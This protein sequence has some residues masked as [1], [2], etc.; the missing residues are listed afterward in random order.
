MSQLGIGIRLLETLTSALYEDP[1]VLF[2]EYVQ[3]SIDSFNRGK[4]ADEFKIDI[5]INEN[6]RVITI[7]D[8]GN[9]IAKSNFYKQ[10]SMIAGSDKFGEIDQIGFRGIGRLSAMPFCDELIFIN[11]ASGENTLQK[12]T[13]NGKKYKNL[14]KVDKEE[15][16]ESIVDEISNHEL[17]IPYDGDESD[18]FFKVEIK[19]YN[20]EINLL[21]NNED[22][23]ARLCLLLPL[24][25]DPEFKYK[26]EIHDHYKKFMNSDLKIFE[27]N[28]FLNGKPLYKL[29]K[30]NNILESEIIFWDLYFSK[31]DKSLPSEKI[32][33]IWF[34]FSRKLVI[35]G[36]STLRGI[37][38]RSKNMLLGDETSIVSAVMK[39]N[40]EYIT[41]RRELEQTVIGVY[42]EIL[43]DNANLSD[44][45]RRD[46]FRLDE[47]SAQL[48]LILTDFLKKLYE[49]RYA[50]S[51]IFNDKA[52]KLK[53]DRVVNAYNNLTQGI[54]I[55]TLIN[56]LD[57]SAAKW[58]GK[59]ESA[60][61]KFAEEDIPD[62]SVTSKK[63]YEKI[64]QTIKQY[65][66]ENDNDMEEFLRLRV[67]L[68]NHLKY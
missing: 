29:F 31:K 37:R 14:L 7:L 49:Y 54:N 59:N 60:I 38:V 46:W 65:F 63:L 45:A 20:D 57:N 5:N 62:A 67:Y 52:G 30:D 68:K 23:E 13:W 1:I 51:E 28:V 21:V 26:D 4:V 42:G 18:H 10:M 39:S 56:Q 32:G 35:K 66:E 27:A 41:T 22:F 15:E 8:N 43:L 17:E 36:N 50:A 47:H 33:I 53:R 12:F 40:N 9:G 55:E 58:K 25:Y 34:T 16:L 44:N 61:F 11:K 24:K 6:D 64:M 48:N 19:N 2:R 3:N